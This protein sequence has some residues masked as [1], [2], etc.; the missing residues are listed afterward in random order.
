MRRGFQPGEVINYV[1]V[2][3]PIAKS[4]QRRT[5]R[6]YVVRCIAPNKRKKGGICGKLFREQYYR[7]YYRNAYSC[8]CIRRHKHP[9]VRLEDQSCGRLFVTR[10]VVEEGMWEA[11]CTECGQMMYF[12]RQG[13]IERQAGSCEE[14]KENRRFG[15]ERHLH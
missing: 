10:W 1:E 14:H 2:V 15:A 8:G 12:R 13:D 6:D 7:L 11:G 5:N 9:A 3:E 4:A